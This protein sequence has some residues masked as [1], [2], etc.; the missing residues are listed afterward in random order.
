[1]DIAAIVSEGWERQERSFRPLDCPPP[2]SLK[3]AEREMLFVPSEALSELARQAF[4]EINFFFRSS[5]LKQWAAILEDAAASPAERFVAAALLQNASIAAEGLLPTCQDTGTAVIWALKGERV[6]TDT[7]DVA[8]LE[9][10]IR[11]AYTAG[12][13]R[14]SQLVPLDIFAETNTGTNLPAQIDIHTVRGAEYRLLFIAKGAGSAN[15][16]ALYSQTKVILNDEAFAAFL[17]EKIAALGVAACPPYHLAVVVGGTSPEF[18]LQLLKLATA[19][20]LDTLPQQPDGSGRPYRDRTWEQR[21]QQIAERS[22]LG[23]QFGGKYLALDARLIRCARHGGSCF[24]SLGVSCSADRH[25]W[26]KITRHGVLLEVLDHNPDRYL[27]RAVEAMESSLFAAAPR[28]DLDCPTD[29]VCRVL[30]RHP[31]GAPVLLSGTLISARDAAHARFRE[32]LRREGK[33]PDYLYNHAIYYAGPAGTPPGCVIGSFGPTTA[34]RM[35]EY[36]PEFMAHGASLITLGKGPRAITV[37]EACRR[38]GGFYLGVIGGAAALIARRHIRQCEVID[39]ADLGMEA[40][41]RVVVEDL[42]AF[43]LIDDKGNDFYAF[44]RR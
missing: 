34:A 24:I 32:R 41:R 19:G 5:Q 20:A 33:L 7:D 9:E 21:L 13:L 15:K 28:V 27:S 11:A 23:A 36:L 29:E 38:Y 6:F 22:G 43:I 44:C 25:I 14:A 3:F 30:S 18:N 1:M 16:T 10:G 31:V 17:E 26:G 4:R 42:P 37:A 35:D 12:N 39:F 8:V 40:V 2:K